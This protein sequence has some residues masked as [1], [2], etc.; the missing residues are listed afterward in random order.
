MQHMR[1]L[2]NNEHISQDMRKHYCAAFVSINAK[3]HTGGKLEYMCNTGWHQSAW[4][5]SI[6]LSLQ[7]HDIHCTV[8]YCIYVTKITCELLYLDVS[9]IQNVSD[10]TTLPMGTYDSFS[11]GEKGLGLLRSSRHIQ[12]AEDLNSFDYHKAGARTGKSSS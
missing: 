11:S 4:H 1:M 7:Q 12:C 6:T 5:L 8:L 3:R 9:Y 2:F 10:N